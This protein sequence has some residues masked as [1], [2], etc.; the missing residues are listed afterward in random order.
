MASAR[1]AEAIF[2]PVNNGN[3]YIVGTSLQVGAT[4]GGQTPVTKM[5]LYVDGNS[6]YQ[7]SGNT[8]QASVSLSAGG[9]TLAVEAA[10]SSGNLATNQFSVTSA[11]PNVKI[12]SPAANSTFYS[13][14]YVSAL[15]TDPTPVKGIQVYMDG[16]LLYEVTGTG[17]QNSI[18]VSIGKRSVTVQEWNSSGASYKQTI[19]VNVTGVPITISSP[20]ANATVGPTFTVTAS[21]PS[22]SPVQTMQIYIDDKMVYQVRGQ[23][24][25]HSFTLS[26]GQHKIVAKGWDS[27]GNN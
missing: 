25:S 24:V 26:S 10:D 6:K 2:L 18:P 20:K 5:Q 9:H 17:I 11:S 22:S 15:A 19:N 21:A 12:L 1:N 4:A 23:S 7:A 8:L 27:Y 14:M 16:T 3:A 13:P